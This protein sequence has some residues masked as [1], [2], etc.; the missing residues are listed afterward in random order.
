LLE[1]LTS[2]C[3]TK[4]LL[5]VLVGNIEMAVWLLHGQERV[6]RQLCSALSRRNGLRPTRVRSSLRP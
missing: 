3:G 4:Q 1:S 6:A 2:K 5:V